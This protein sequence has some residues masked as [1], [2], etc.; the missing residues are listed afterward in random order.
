MAAIVRTEKRKRGIFGILLSWMFLAFNAFMGLWFFYT[1]TIASETVGEGTN[2][3]EQAA[4][5]IT[6]DVLLWLWPIGSVIL[7]LVLA[8]TRGKTVTIEK[9]IDR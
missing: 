9:V 6:A 3:E 2:A 8:L 4:A 7:G 1:I 5:A